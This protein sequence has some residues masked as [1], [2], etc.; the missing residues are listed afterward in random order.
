MESMARKNLI[1]HI[2]FDGTVNQWHRFNLTQLETFAHVFDGQI[3]VKL[4]VNDLEQDITE[5]SPLIPFPFEMVQNNSLNEASHFLDSL[6]RISGGITFY[7]HC[8]GVT[9]GYMWGM[10]QWIRML[11]RW[12]LSKYPVLNG[13]IFSGVCAKLLPCPPYVPEPFH[14]SGSFYWMDTD[15]AKERWRER[16]IDYNSYLTER[17]PA[18]CSEMSECQFNEVATRHN[19]NFYADQTWISIFNEK[20]RYYEPYF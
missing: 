6:E 11:Y 16:K 2:Y 1:Y 19:V 13:K 9:R 4:A 15:K 17:F 7:A 18:I 12:N 3:I 8:K 10:E 20:S 5:I 14:Y